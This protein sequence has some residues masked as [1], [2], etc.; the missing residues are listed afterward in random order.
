MGYYIGQFYFD[1]RDIFLILAI[2]L[3]VFAIR[4]H[5]PIPYF[6]TN[7]LF[8]LLIILLIAKGFVLPVYD[9]AI[10]VIF[11]IALFLTLFVPLFQSLVFLVCAFLFLRLFKVI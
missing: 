1:K 9:S 10:F 2:I 8:F 7:H 6:D 5:Y 4:T 3:L 11:L